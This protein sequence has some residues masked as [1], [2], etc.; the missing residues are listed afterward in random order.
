ME[1]SVA[2]D[3]V[4]GVSITVVCLLWG[5]GSSAPWR[6]FD[7]TGYAL[8]AALNL[9]TLLRR[10]IPVSV[11]AVYCVLWLL[12][13]RAG[14][15]PAVNSFGAMLL[16]YTVAAS[17]PRPVAVAGAAL[18]AGIW[19]YG[20]LLDPHSSAPFVVAQSI[21]LSAI[22]WKV[23]DCARELADRG[24]QLAVYAARLRS[25]QE[26]LARR[27]VIDEQLRI[28]RELHDVVAHHLSVV[29]IQAG[30]ARYVLESDPA[31]ADQ[32]LGTVLDTT[33]EALDELRRL[34]AVLRTGTQ[35]PEE[36]SEAFHPS[37]GLAQL[38]ELAAR[39]RAAG[40]PVEVQVTGSARPLPPGADL[41]AYRVIQEC[42][43][44][45]LKH[46]A[47]ARTVVGLHYGTDALHARVT[48]DGRGLPAAMPAGDCQGLGLAGMCERVRLYG[49]S[50]TAGPRPG[51]GWTVELTLPLPAATRPLGP[52][53]ESAARDDGRREVVRR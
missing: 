11:L 46:A 23:G 20:G 8:T 30:L 19:L 6:P 24:T 53:A 21:V 1:G 15:W 49:G 17:R 40:V 47:G 13:I 43:T 51:S 42:L 31:T 12:Y 3:V 41:C 44:N 52:P 26:E 38:D 7:A 9:L 33:G 25:D 35:L 36:A 48:D 16:G 45:V 27:A 18:G 39:M 32:A 37:P 10:R 50:V 29:S 14:Y 5:H 4:L 2:V 28:A 22:V 34:L